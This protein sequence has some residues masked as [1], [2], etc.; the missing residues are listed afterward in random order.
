MKYTKIVLI[1][2]KNITLIITLEKKDT[3]LQA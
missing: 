2:K 3:D 1:K